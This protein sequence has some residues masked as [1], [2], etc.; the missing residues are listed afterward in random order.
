MID[1]EAGSLYIHT[2]TKLPI[3]MPNMKIIVWTRKAEVVRR[4]RLPYLGGNI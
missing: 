1:F 2:F 3:H 4:A